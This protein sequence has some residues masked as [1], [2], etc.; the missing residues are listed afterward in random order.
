MLVLSRKLGERIIIGDN[1]TIEIVRFDGRTVRL[2]ITAPVATLIAREEIIGQP[3]RE[4]ANA[5]DR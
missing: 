3:K 1:I 5:V 2:G 4:V